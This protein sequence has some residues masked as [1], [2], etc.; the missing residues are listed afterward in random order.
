VAPEE[1]I[2]DKKIYDP[3]K[4]ISTYFMIAPKEG[5]RLE[6]MRLWPAQR[7]Y[8]NNR[9]HRDLILK[10]RQMGISTGILAA[11]AQKLFTKKHL[12][13]L[14]VAHNDETAKFLMLNLARWYN[15]MEP[16][17]QNKVSLKWKSADVKYFAGSDVYAYCDSA[18]STDIGIG[19]TLHYVHL[20]EMARW[21]PNNAKNLYAGVSQ[22]APKDGYITIESTP[23]GKVGLFYELYRDAKKGENDFKTFFFPWW[24]GVDYHIPEV[25]HIKQD[26]DCEICA[27]L[28]NMS[29]EAFYAQEKSMMERHSLSAG[30]IMWR[31]GKIK[32][33]R[34][35]LFF[36]EYPENDMD[37]WLTSEFGVIDGLSLQSYYDDIRQG[38]QE[39]EHLTIWKDNI[40][41]HTYVMGVDAASGRYKDYSVAAVLDT[42][43]LEYVAR[44]RTNRMPPDI[45]AEEVYR[46]GMRYNTAL[47]AVEREQNGRDVLR[48][49]TYKN[50]PNMYYHTTYDSYG[51]IDV[52]DMG[53]RTDIKTKASMI[54][55]LAAAFRSKALVSYSENLLAEASA[56]TYEDAPGGRVKTARGETDDEFIAVSIAIQVREHSPMVDFGLDDGKGVVQHYAPSV[57]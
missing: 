43:N 51:E 37:C 34:G 11:N 45:F 54:T 57:L 18:K 8:I 9:T 36:Q 33:L 35:P 39:G 48:I 16:D 5:A 15:Q 29:P 28:L 17:D 10:G 50:Y 56:I 42:K 55:D 1:I 20:T 41:G 13:M 38:K 53:W 46:L 25:F 27:G 30:H 2:E 31:R 44:I 24:M 52:Q 19:H 47:I 12:N 23:R 26:E 7:Y 3:I 22:T 21:H 14:L 49:L 40:G 6:P 32:E 4:Y